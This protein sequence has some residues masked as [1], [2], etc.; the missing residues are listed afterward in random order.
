MSLDA[1][2]TTDSTILQAVLQFALG[3]RSG[4]GLAAPEIGAARRLSVFGLCLR[5]VGAAVR[6]EEC[7]HMI[8]RVGLSPMMASAG[9]TCATLVDKAPSPANIAAAGRA[10]ALLSV[11]GTISFHEDG[12]EALSRCTGEIGRRLELGAVP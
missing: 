6:E 7:L 3:T 5:A 2:T 4:H 1:S 12:R 11:I 9:R 10:Q 8:L